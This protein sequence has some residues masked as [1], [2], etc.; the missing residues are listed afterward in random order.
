[1]YIFFI[2][3]VFSN[4]SEYFAGCKAIFFIG[5]LYYNKVLISVKIAPPFCLLLFQ[6]VM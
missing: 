5:M 2:G 6:V 3:F 1:M 4:L